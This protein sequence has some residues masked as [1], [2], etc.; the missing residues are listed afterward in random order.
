MR[1]IDL[2]PDAASLMWSTRAIGYT[3]PAAVADLIDNSISAEATKIYIK[4]IPGED[5][6]VSIL[7]DGR[8]LH[9][10]HNARS[11]PLPV[12]RAI[13]FVLIHGIWTISWIPKPAIGTFWNWRKERLEN[14]HKLKH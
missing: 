7:D 1:P 2:P 12:R 9:P 8:R 3:T 4:Y 13:I 5:G 10:Y 11:L 14:C 6:Y